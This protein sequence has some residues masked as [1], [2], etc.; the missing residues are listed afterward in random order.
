MTGILTVPQRLALMVYDASPLIRYTTDVFQEKLDDVQRIA[1]LIEIAE[2]EYPPIAAGVEKAQERYDIALIGDK[3][4]QGADEAAERALREAADA[5]IMY[6]LKRTQ[7]QFPNLRN[8]TDVT[9]AGALT[10]VEIARVQ[11]R[12][13]VNN[14]TRGETTGFWG[15]VLSVLVVYTVSAL[16]LSNR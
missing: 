5:V 1:G 3:Y 4:G 6:L 2:A 12:G 13:I 15:T 9:A 16:E 14:M 10:G 7:L 8:R 11:R